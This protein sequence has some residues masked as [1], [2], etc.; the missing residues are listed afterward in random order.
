[1]KE[2]TKMHIRR[3]IERYLRTHNMPPTAFGRL[4]VRDPR[5][6]GDM[7]RGREVGREIEARVAAFMRRQ[8]R[9]NRALRGGTC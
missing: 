9:R 7:R 2:R 5:L 6:V 3:K 1:M 4:S 8:R